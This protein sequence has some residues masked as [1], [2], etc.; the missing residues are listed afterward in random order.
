[1]SDAKALG[2]VKNIQKVA[3]TCQNQRI[4]IL[5]Q[6]NEDQHTKK[7]KKEKRREHLIDTSYTH[8]HLPSSNH[9]NLYKVI[10]LCRR[11]RPNLTVITV[12]I[13]RRAEK[14]VFHV[15]SKAFPTRFEFVPPKWWKFLQW[16]LMKKNI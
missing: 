13:T 16:Q 1:M 6:Q 10:R 3:F 7:M 11:R 12:T 2:S 8:I 14:H 5:G 9:L 15:I 4:S